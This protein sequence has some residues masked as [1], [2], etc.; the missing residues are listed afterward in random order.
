[1]KIADIKT[2][3]RLY[4]VTETETAYGG[5]TFELEAGAVVWGDFRPD[6]PVVE[7]G[8]GDVGVV[9][10]ADFL[11]RSAAGLA[12]GG[13]LSLKGFDWTIVSVDEDAEGVVR[14]RIGRVHP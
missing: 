4:A 5:R 6:V 12:R 10:E 11:C 14:V 13:R 9:Q 2:P 7:S 3:A 8:E 1:V